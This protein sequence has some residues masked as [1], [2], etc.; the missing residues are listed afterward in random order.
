MYPWPGAECR[1]RDRH[2]GVR[3]QVVTRAT[4]SLWLITLLITCNYRQDLNQGEAAPV[5]FPLGVIPSS[6][7]LQSTAA[8]PQSRDSSPHSEEVVQPS[9]C[10]HVIPL[11][12]LG[13]VCASPSPRSLEAEKS[14][15]LLPEGTHAVYVLGDAGWGPGSPQKGHL[16]LLPVLLG[17]S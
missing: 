9:W 13:L 1:R 12:V 15:F 11:P 16:M 17:L 2:R 7:C 5:R 6:G 14:R 10:T 8:S 3:V 4:S